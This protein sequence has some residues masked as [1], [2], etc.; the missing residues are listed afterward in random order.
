MTFMV[1]DRQPERHERIR[2]FI[3]DGEPVI[4]VLLATADFEWTVRRAILA[5]GVSPNTHIRQSVL[6]NC[7][8]LD[9]YK[10][11]WKSEVKR[12]LGRTLPD[13]VGDWSGLIKAFDLRHRLVHG[14]TGTTGFGYAAEK[15]ECILH[16]SR[17]VTEFAKSNNVDLFGRLPVRRK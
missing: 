5:L 11:A 9:K 10:D 17:S 14:I 8:G 3:K 4:S 1:G 13:V 7:S 2:Q 6:K 12:R 15:V 16:A